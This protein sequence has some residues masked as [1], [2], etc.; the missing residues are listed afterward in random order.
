VNVWIAQ[1]RK[2]TPCAF[3]GEDINCGEYMAVGVYYRGKWRH[4]K[5]WHPQCWIDEGIDYA[6][7]N[8]KPETRGRKTLQL[9]DEDRKRRFRILARRASI[10]QRAKIAYSKGN[11]NALAK[12][13][14][15][16]EQLKEE[17]KPLGGVP[18]SWN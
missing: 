15:Q 6:Q 1:C 12:Y 7:R 13:G 11:F 17:I 8:P 5:S 10:I 9:K 14:E 16:L 2:R 4:R 3:C 18:E